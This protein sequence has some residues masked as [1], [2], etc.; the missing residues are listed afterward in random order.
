MQGLR[1]E[2]YP[3]SVTDPAT[4]SKSTSRELTA[5]IAYHEAFGIEAPWPACIPEDTI[6][7]VLERAIKR[8]RPLPKGYNWWAYLPLGAVA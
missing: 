2:A 5:R 6:A 4:T 7:E 1:R 8:G 3:A